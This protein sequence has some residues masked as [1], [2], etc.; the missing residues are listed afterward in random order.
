M[1]QGG[2]FCSGGDDGRESGVNTIKIAQ[3]QPKGRVTMTQFLFNYPL[4][5]ASLN[6]RGVSVYMLLLS[7]SN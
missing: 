6:Q 4:L 1:K 3:S 7:R 5:F 2:W